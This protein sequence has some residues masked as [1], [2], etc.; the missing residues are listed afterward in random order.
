MAPEH[1]VNPI[2]RLVPILSRLLA[3]QL[4][5]P[6]PEAAV[7]DYLAELTTEE[8]AELQELLAHPDRP[9]FIITPDEISLIDDNK[10]LMLLFFVSDVSKTFKSTTLTENMEAEMDGNEAVEGDG[11]STQGPSAGETTNNGSVSGDE[12]EMD[13]GSRKPPTLAAPAH[14]T[15]STDGPLKRKRELEDDA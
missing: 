7:L 4:D 3:Q 5:V 11:P 8:R 14:I 13:E 15:G 10:Q 1:T 9:G 2:R 12:M 6:P